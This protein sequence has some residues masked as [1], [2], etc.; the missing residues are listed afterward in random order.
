M[1]VDTAEITV[2]AGAGGNGSVSFHREKY[3]PAGGPD[4]GDGGRGGDII[5]RADDNMSTLMDF[6][7]KTK[8]VASDGEPGKG[9]KCFGKDAPPL[10]I[11]LPRGTVVKDKASGTVIADM[12]AHD[13]FVAFFKVQSVV[14][15]ESGAAFANTFAHTFHNSG[16]TCNFPVTFS[17]EAHAFSHDVLH[18]K[19][20]KLFHT[21]QILEGICKCVRINV[22]LAEEFFHS[23]FDLSLI[24]NSC[25]VIGNHGVFFIVFCHFS[26]EFFRSN[27]SNQFSK[28][29]NCVG[30]AFPTEFDFNFYFVTVGN[31]NITHVVAETSN[32]QF[33]AENNAGSGTHP[34]GD[35]S[36][37][38]RIFPVANYYFARHTQTGSHKA[39]FTV[40]MSGLVEVH[41]VHVHG[42]VRNVLVVLSVEMEKRFLEAYQPFDPHLGR[43]EGVC[44]DDNTCTLI[45]IVHFFHQFGD[46]F[47]A[48]YNAFVDD[49]ARKTKFVHLVD[50]VICMCNTSIDRFLAIK[51]LAAGDKPKFQIFESSHHKYHSPY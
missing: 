43:R 13:E 51:R 3:V 21:V 28:L 27:F 10:V 30:V 2:R 1:F 40:A 37:N 29:V 34:A 38:V 48:G 6:R 45:L 22:R 50:H 15:H 23:D 33:F 17:A 47:G 49:F 19:T 5:L 7:Y 41:E 12:S 20:G 16:K 25:D 11:R 4:G 8:Y 44:E 26:S 9:K 32:F 42:S 46:F 31:A 39:G 35:F 14:F 24:F 18:C 36:G